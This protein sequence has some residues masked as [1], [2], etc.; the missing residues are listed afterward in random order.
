VLAPPAGGRDL[1]EVGLSLNGV[2]GRLTGFALMIAFG[3][4]KSELWTTM[5]G[6]WG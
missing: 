4:V 1:L 5:E 6:N 3:R 2:F